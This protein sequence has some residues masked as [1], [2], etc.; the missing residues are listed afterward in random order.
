MP[1]PQVALGNTH[2]STPLNPSNSNLSSDGFYQ[3]ILDSTKGGSSTADFFTKLNVLNQLYSQ[4]NDDGESAWNEGEDYAGNPVHYV[5]K[6]DGQGKAY[7]MKVALEGVETDGDKI[8]T[9]EEELVL[10]GKTYK[11]VGIVFYEIGYNNLPMSQASN[12]RNRLMCV[13]LTSTLS[14]TTKSLV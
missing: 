2:T 14:A 3:Q 4:I 9:N 13:S 10:D 5:S 6:E 8:K 1:E 11:G 12:H 7:Y